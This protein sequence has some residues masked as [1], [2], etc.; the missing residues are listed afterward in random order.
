MGFP[1]A[2]FEAS[3]K[4][5]DMRTKGELEGEKVWKQ[6]EAKIEELKSN[7]WYVPDATKH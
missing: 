3:W 2:A 7:G 6:I 4:A 1:S 5:K